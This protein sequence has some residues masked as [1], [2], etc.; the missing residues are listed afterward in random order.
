MHA[1]EFSRYELTFL[2]TGV[3]LK[4]VHQLFEFTP[5]NLATLMLAMRSP[6]AQV[7]T[8]GLSQD[9]VVKYSAYRGAMQL[10]QVQP[11]ICYLWLTTPLGCSFQVLCIPSSL[12]A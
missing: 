3:Q 1:G 4:V 8:F 9:S 5:S 12:R 6:T 11:Q 7:T 2:S 10:M